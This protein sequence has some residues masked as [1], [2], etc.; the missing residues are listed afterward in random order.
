MSNRKT[1][2]LAL[3]AALG[4]ASVA[5]AQTQS[6]APTPPAAPP[7]ATEPAPAGGPDGYRNLH[8]FGPGMGMM[9]EHG[10]GMGGRRLSKEDRAAFFDARIAAMHAG[11]RLTPDQ[12]KL[13]PAVE[14]AVR[15]MS[16][17]M[18][19][20]YDKR[21]A[22]GQPK[23]PID[24]MRRMADAQIARG[25]AMKKV[26]DAAA[27]LYA[28]LSAEQKA[29]LPQLAHPGMRERVGAWMRDHGMHW[30]LGRDDGPRGGRGRGRDDDDRPMMRRDRDDRG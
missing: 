30:G 8:G 22:A 28:T 1:A 7:A 29:R 26:A 9:M 6:P 27:P 24:G 18:S 5:Y 4:V 19:D 10:F 11:L 17:S 23:D 2:V 13:W 12:E 3:A 14:S 20:L 21:R 25:E 15:D 16:K